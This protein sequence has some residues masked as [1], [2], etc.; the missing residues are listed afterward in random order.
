MC[1]TYSSCA[2]APAAAIAAAAAPAKADVASEL[3]V[4]GA[5]MSLV[6]VLTL[7]QVLDVSVHGTHWTPRHMTLLMLV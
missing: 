7:G 6:F 4:A 3:A 5:H 1:S 2:T